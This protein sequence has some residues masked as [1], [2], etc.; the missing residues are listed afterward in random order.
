M[1]IES[2]LP[3]PGRVPRI[4]HIIVTLLQPSCYLLHFLLLWTTHIKKQDLQKTH[5]PV[6]S[7][8]PQLATAYNHRHTNSSA[9]RLFSD[10]QTKIPLVLFH[11]NLTERF[12][13]RSLTLASSNSFDYVGKNQETSVPKL[14]LFPSVQFS[15]INMQSF[16]KFRSLSWR[17]NF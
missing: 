10:R 6:L 2:G 14:S 16:L 7:S 3:L 1:Y 9:Q 17:E 13:A 8:T 4:T 11:A 15:S 5:N 12:G